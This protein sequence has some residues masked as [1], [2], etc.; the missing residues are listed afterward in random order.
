MQRCTPTF[1]VL[2]IGVMSASC[3][4]V[5]GEE[6]ASAANAQQIAPPILPPATQLEAFKPTAG[7]VLTFGY[8]ELGTVRGVSVD[9]RE[10][11][12]ARGPGARGLVVGVKES[13]YRQ[14]SSFV[15]A[16]EIP[17]LLKGLDTLLQVKANPTPFRRFE[18][19]YTTRGEL[20]LVA[21][22]DY[23]GIFFSVTAGRTFKA[24]DVGFDLEEMQKLRGF[25]EA[26][27]QK[28]STLGPPR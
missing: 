12:D 24:H 13:Q 18:V 3:T 14:E 28:L 27:Q 16:D 10:M 23:R 9:V 11:R 8:D 15:D 21:Y 20:Q 26:A 1:L 22:N 17:E 2:S 25:F 7:S 6:Q 19:R 5:H 4:S